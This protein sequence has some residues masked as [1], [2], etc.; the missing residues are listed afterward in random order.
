MDYLPGFL[1]SQF[2]ITPQKPTTDC[3][4]KTIIVTGANIGLGK[5]ASRHFVAL[6]CSKLILACRSTEKGEAA[7]LDIEK[8]T[9]RKGVIEVWQL[10]LESYDSVKE[11]AKR[12]QGL[13]RVDVLLENAGVATSEYKVA[14]GNESTITV[15]VISTFL[16]ALLMLPK[17]QETGRKFN[18]TPTLTIV[19]SEVHNFTPFTERKEPSI[20][21]YINAKATAKMSD[22]YNLSKLLEILTIRE[23]TRLHPASQLH[24][25]LN[26]VN[27]G[28]C[29]SG[30]MRELSG[31]LL[32]TLIKKIMCRTTEVGSRTLVDAALKGE[33]THGKYLSNCQ[34]TK[35][36]PLVEGPEGPELQR[37]V[38]G[39]VQEVLE[40]IEPGVTRNL[41]S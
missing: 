15:N 21:P 5:E 12:A 30:L 2:F 32:V 40:G 18:I 10:D 29:H 38:W 34:I 9:G 14:E 17:L 24:I 35:C 33:E 7:K 28:W 16:L 26:T 27:P 13:E 31:N 19:S 8:T 4:G 3:T 23:I 25:T 6:N 11:F 20:L 37:R 36:S 1:Y 22:R 41:E 39:E